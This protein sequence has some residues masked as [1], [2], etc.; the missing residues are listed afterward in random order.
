MDIRVKSFIFLARVVVARLI[1]KEKLA[2][3]LTP[4]STRLYRS[5]RHSL[6]LLGLG[7]IRLYSV[8]GLD[9]AEHVTEYRV[10]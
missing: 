4:F 3:K 7:F 9:Y 8:K 6:P 10:Y 2:G 1:L 5:I